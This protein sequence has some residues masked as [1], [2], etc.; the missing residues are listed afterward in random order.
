[1]RFATKAIHYGQE[2]EK[3]TGAVTVPIFQTSTYAQDDIGKTKGYEYSRTGNP[4][5][6]ALE[7]VIASLEGGS[8]GFA[9]SS[10]M[11]ATDSV[12]RLLSHGDHV[13]VSDDVYGGT[14]RLFTKVMERFGLEFSFVDTSDIKVLE[15][16]I[17]PST[18]M[19]WIESPSNPLLKLTDI[20]SA[21]KIARSKGILTIVDNTFM[22]PYF[23]RPLEL[24]CDIVVHSTTKYLGGHSDVVGGA[25]VSKDP[26]ISERLKF[27]QNSAGAIPGPFDCWLVLRGI[28]TL[29][30][31]M[32]RH[33]ANAQAVAEFLENHSKVEKV[34]Y[35]GLKSHPQHALAK[36]Q[37]TG[38]GGMVSFWP[39]GG[40]ASSRVIL[41]STRLFVLAESLG[42]VE[43]LISCP[44]AMTHASVPAEA[45]KKTGIR[46][47]LIRLSVGI[48]DADDLIED[49]DRSFVGT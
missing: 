49:L 40:M 46:D 32:E 20:R 5:R 1:M 38:F 23:Q 41:R 36:R 39:K 45:R 27:I 22:S 4:T 48:E 7:T 11:S 15:R 10:G 9:F 47:D 44:S 12:V 17:R 6:T 24:G 28:K 30:L 42:G 3:T 26:E 37:M 29:A 14:Y 13:V 35:P 34:I 18:K 19:L 33:N 2:P 21:S 25:V 31:R 8:H 16:A 43:S